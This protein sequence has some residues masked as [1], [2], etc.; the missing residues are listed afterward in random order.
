MA[1]GQPVAVHADHGEAVGPHLKEGAGVDG[2]GL[3]VADGE[4]GLADHG[5]QLVPG[6]GEAVLVLH[7]GQLGEVLGIGGQDVELA[8]AAGDVHQV[9]VGGEGDHVVGEL[10]DDLAEEPG[11]QHQAAGPVDLGGDHG[12]D[13]GLQVVAGEAEL[14]AGLQEDALQGGDGALGGDGPGCGGDGRLKECFFTGE[15]HGGG[16]PSFRAPLVFEERRG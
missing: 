13:A 11:G 12:A 8:H 16:F 15:F 10:A 5:P 4:D 6:N 14:L 7:G 3:V 9:A 2:P 1:E